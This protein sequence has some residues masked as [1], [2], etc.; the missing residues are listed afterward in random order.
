MGTLGTLGT[1][2]AYFIEFSWCE[3][4]ARR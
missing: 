3:L 2:K 4:T 1:G